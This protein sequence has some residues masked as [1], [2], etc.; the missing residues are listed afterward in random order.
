MRTAWWK[1]LSAALG[2]S[3][4]CLGLLL[5]SI[6]AAGPI[7][8]IFT[9]TVTGISVFGPPPGIFDSSVQVGT[10]ALVSYIVDSS[11]PNQNPDPGSGIYG[12]LGMLSHIGQVPQPLGH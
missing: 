11:A 3:V 4:A 2:L 12:F 6:A 5:P 8:F 10:P 1:F 9:G 7:K